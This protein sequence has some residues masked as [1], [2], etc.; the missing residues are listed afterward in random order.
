[1]QAHAGARGVPGSATAL[2]ALLQ[3]PNVL[4][5]WVTAARLFGITHCLCRTWLS[6]T[7]RE[8]RR[9]LIWISVLHLRWLMCRLSNVKGAENAA[10]VAATLVVTCADTA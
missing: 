7:S 9:V 5:V 1:M 8:L 6:D 3:A 4:E 10:P 2:V